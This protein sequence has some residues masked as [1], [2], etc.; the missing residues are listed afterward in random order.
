MTTQPVHFSFGQWLDD[1]ALEHQLAGLPDR[2]A[3]TLSRAFPLEALLRACDSVAA[4]LLGQGPLWLR[5]LEMT[6]ESSM[7]HSADTTLRAIATSMRRQQLEEKLRR[8]LGSADPE[9]LQRQYPERW[10]EAWKPLG[11]L[12]HV[13][14]ANVLGVAA[15]G[16]VEGLL[17]GNVNLVKTSARDTLLAQVLAEALC[18]ADPGGRLR[19]YISVVRIPSNRTDLLQTLF[20]SADGISAW[21]GEQAIAHVK[22]M[23]PASAKVVAWGHRISFGYLAAECF[24]DHGAWEGF[25]TDVCRLEQQACSSPQ[26]LFVECDE[27]HLEQAGRRLS[28]ALERVSPTLE[29]VRPQGMEQAEITTTALVARLERPLGLTDVFEAPDGSWRV[30]VDHRQGLRPSPLFRTI[31]VK[32]LPRDEIASTLRPMRSWLQTAG[33]AC[34]RSSV[35]ELSTALLA[36]GVTRITQPGRMVDSYNGSPH[37]GVYALQQFS[38]RV[39]ID[40]GQSLADVGSLE[41]MAGEMAPPQAGQALMTKSDFQRRDVAHQW[42]G[43]VVRSGGSSGNPAFSTFTWDGYREQMLAAANGLCAAGLEPDRDRVM[44]LYYA[45]HLYGSFISFWTILEHLRVSQLPMTSNVPYEEI[46]EAIGRF[47]PN[48]LIGMPSLLLRLFREHEAALRETGCIEKVFYGGEPMTDSQKSWLREHFGV[49]R[50]SSS[51]YGSNDA[52]PMGYQCQASEGN[53][54]HL[55]SDIQTLEIL[56]LESDEPVVGDAVGRLVLTPRGSSP[57][58]VSRYEIGDLGRW[59]EGDCLCGRRDP[60]F[61]LMGR[62]GDAFK[63]GGPF[64]NVQRFRHLLETEFGYRGVMQIHVDVE[65]TR[66]RIALWVDRSLETPPDE[67]ARRLIDRYPELAITVDECK[68]LFQVTPVADN[69][70]VITA[71]SGKLRPLCDHRHDPS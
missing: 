39:S 17:A 45:G 32:R 54:H 49:R 67:V 70:F 3:R 63:A 36:G 20:A 71:A 46:A 31:W 5:L 66:N 23:A 64:L 14:P 57:L 1:A 26:T 9:A 50:V 65:G 10:H 42:S 21:G 56:K 59:V 30:L 12:V 19:D 8:E 68:S 47:R 25:A 4:E 27:A 38:R 48:V 35:Y 44:N 41:Q 22:A 58:R 13:A 69:G 11:C 40:L 53:V 51:I 15:M 2:L 55:L 37:D 61:E 18:A 29:Q 34:G 62:L 7:A 52:G 43:L 33:L 24:D 16:L 6:Q 28:D 60:R